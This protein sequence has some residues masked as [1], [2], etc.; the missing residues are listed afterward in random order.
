MVID[1]KNETN[2]ET[3]GN[4]EPKK[5]HRITRMKLEKIPLK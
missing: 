3:L 4:P 2:K 5:N 1:K